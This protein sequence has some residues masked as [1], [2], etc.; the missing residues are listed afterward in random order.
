MAH[1]SDNY[2][3]QEYRLGDADCAALFA[4]VSWEVFGHTP[5]TEADIERAQSAFGRALQV[6]DGVDSLGKPADSPKEGDAVLMM[7]RG[8]PSHIGVFCVV[9]GEKCVLHAMQNAGMVVRHRL[10][11]L[12]RVNL[13]VEGFYTWVS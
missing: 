2:I 8:R 10:R 3:G 4:R 6:A 5:P 12:H 1:W 9:D 11:E 7:C 13:Q